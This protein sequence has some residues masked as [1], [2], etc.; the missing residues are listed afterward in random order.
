MGAAAVYLVNR[1]GSV[2]SSLT[3]GTQAITRTSPDYDVVR[4]LNEII[5]GGPTGRLFLNLREDKG[6]TYGAYSGLTAMRYRGDWS[7]SAEV[8]TE[9]TEGAIRETLAEIAGTRDQALPLAAVQ[10]K[11][12]LLVANFALS[13]ESPQGLLSNYITGYLYKL[14]ADYWDKY[15]ERVMAVTPAQVQAAAKKY[16]DS[17]RLQIVVVG[18]GS[19]IT[20]ALR[21]FGPLQV[22]DTEGK[23]VGQ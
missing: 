2:Q 13:L 6:W 21:K 1:P 15:P 7:A 5:G 17:S 9:V 16:L 3:V 23:K 20:E 14:P 8:R 19:K 11:Q 12:R 4:L 22:Y 18:D 10:D